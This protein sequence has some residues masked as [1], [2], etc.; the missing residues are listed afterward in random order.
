MLRI[1]LVSLFL[2]TTA[3]HATCPP[4]AQRAPFD[5]D[6]AFDVFVRDLQLGKT[7]LVSIDSTGQGAVGVVNEGDP[8]ISSIS[9]GAK[10][11][12]RRRAAKPAARRPRPLTR[13]R[14]RPAVPPA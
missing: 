4:A 14:F 13:I 6:N 8:A 3:I 1:A 11:T 10:T 9:S 5:F 2:F 12:T 7:T